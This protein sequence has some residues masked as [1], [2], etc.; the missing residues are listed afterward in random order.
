[1]LCEDF[2]TSEKAKKN[3]ILKEEDSA[4]LGAYLPELPSVVVLYEAP[5]LGTALVKG[6]GALVMLPAPL[7]SEE[8][9]LS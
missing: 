4:A 8:L 1:M 5:L 6:A 7:F 2:E 9:L 3:K